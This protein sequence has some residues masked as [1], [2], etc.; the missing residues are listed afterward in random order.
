MPDPFSVFG[1]RVDQSRSN[2]MAMNLFPQLVRATVAPLASTPQKRNCESQGTK[3]ICPQILA[4]YGPA[5]GVW[6][7]LPLVQ[8]SLGASH[9]KWA[10]EVGR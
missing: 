6:A 8:A 9:H 7:L 5:S 2:Q 4:S 3:S 10:Q 1:F